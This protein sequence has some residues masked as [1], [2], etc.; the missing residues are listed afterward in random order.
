MLPLVSPSNTGNY[1]MFGIIKTTLKI[2]RI[3][4]LQSDQVLFHFHCCKP[5]LFTSL[6]CRLLKTA[7][8]T[9]RSPSCRRIRLEF[10]SYTYL[11]DVE[12]PKTAIKL[13]LLKLIFPGRVLFTCDKQYCTSIKLHF[14]LL[15]ILV[16]Q[17]PNVQ[18]SHHKV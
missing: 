14:Y 16:L 1:I 10:Q 5:L 8:A 9:S 13:M 17:F 4:Q 3:F 11:K 12:L 18:Y 6:F 7:F 2:L 15:D